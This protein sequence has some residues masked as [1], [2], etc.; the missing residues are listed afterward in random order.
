MSPEGVE[1]TSPARFVAD[2][3]AAVFGTLVSWM[4][5]GRRCAIATLV[6]TEG[7][8]PSDP[9][10][11]IVVR[12]DGEHVGGIGVGCVDAAVIDA[13]VEAIRVEQ[14]RAMRFAAGTSQV[15]VS[16]TC[17]NAIEVWVEPCTENVRA[18]AVA[19]SCSGKALLLSRLGHCFAGFE[20]LPSVEVG[21]QWEA[22][23]SPA[24]A[25]IEG[26]AV[27]STVRKPVAHLL[28]AN[29]YSRALTP[30][31]TT[32]GYLVTI[33]DQ[34]PAFLNAMRFDPAATLAFAWPDE[35]LSRVTSDESDAIVSLV[36]DERFEIDALVRAVRSR[37]GYVGALGSRSTAARRRKALFDLG[38]SK[39]E[40][41]RLHAPIGLDIGARTP[42][43][44]ALA[45]VAELLSSRNGRS[46]GSLRDVR[47]PI[48]GRDQ[49]DSALDAVPRSDFSC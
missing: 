44:T 20:D 28:G 32:I 37:A 19:V 43:E 35:Y 17:G 24:F 45:V 12:D 25:L 11:V 8:G 21:R 23:G 22:L 9:G 36:H 13:S 38:C 4:D 49:A 29:E 42:A 6:A 26:V 34:R 46:S 18:F 27:R 41:A 33:V 2:H 15:E 1:C 30:L 47:G 48:R 7:G 14:S 40:V 3:D 5:D 31:L 16:L 39:S 10:T